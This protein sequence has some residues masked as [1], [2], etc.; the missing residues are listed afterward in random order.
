MTVITETMVSRLFET[1]SDLVYRNIGAGDRNAQFQTITSKIDRFG[2]N[3][4]LPN[5]EVVG[6]TFIT[7]PKLNFTTQSLRQDPILSM[8]DTLDPVS[9][10][11]A[12]R[13]YLDTKFSRGKHSYNGT[14]IMRLAEQCPFFNSESPFIIPLSNCLMSMS[15]WPDPVI[16]TET[17]EGGFYSEDQTFAKG[18]D[19]L[20]RSYDLTLT[21]RDIQGGFII[22]L[23]Y[24]WH[25]FIELV[26][27]GEVTAYMEDI[28]ARRLC[29]TCSIYRLVLDPSRQ[30][31]TK[32]AKATGCFP[33]SPPMGSF[34][35][36][37]ERE[38]FITSTA[39][40]SIPFTVN[41]VEYMN[42]L[43]L[44]D[45]NTISKRYSQGLQNLS[46]NRDAMQR[47]PVSPD[48]N[49]TGIP[50]IDLDSGSN[51]LDFWAY[52]NEISKGLL[53]QWNEIK[54]AAN[55]PSNKFSIEDIGI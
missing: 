23:L 36:F 37:G 41:K 45:F 50:F 47:T 1:V 16:D 14:P 39:Q 28:A 8:L 7:R 54:A 31:V 19:R 12:I 52:N 3:M 24:V 44:R 22:A 42:P 34:F 33:K 20:S 9:F 13:C 32:W 11:F 53:T 5:H 25:R 38:S 27:R 18:S 17:T 26:T 2:K 29:Y 40:Y 30:F 48:Y 46:S 55:V 10:Q 51:R 35:N 49:F 21:F 6:L 15:G 43:I 4:L